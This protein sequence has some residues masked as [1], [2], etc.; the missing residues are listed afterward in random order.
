MLVV[1]VAVL[2]A[3]RFFFSALHDFQ[4]ASIDNTHGFQRLARLSIALGV[5]YTLSCMIDIFGTFSVST[6]RL[7]YIRIYT[8]L[9]CI[10]AMLITVCGMSSTFQYFMLAEDVLNECSVLALAGTN[11]AKSIFRGAPWPLAAASSSDEAASQCVNAWSTSSTSQ[12]TVDFL[13]FHIVPAIFQ[14]FIVCVYYSQV[15]S[16]THAASLCNGNNGNHGN[17]NYRAVQLEASNNGNRPATSQSPLY[18]TASTAGFGRTAD[19]ANTRFNGRDTR[20]GGGAMQNILKK[21][22]LQQQNAASAPV[23]GPSAM[24]MRPQAQRASY[25]NA[26]LANPTA[27]VPNPA[28]AYVQGLALTPTSAAPG[29]PSFSVP[30]DAYGSF[31]AYV[32]EIAGDETQSGYNPVEF[33]WQ[34]RR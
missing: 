15:R 25:A 30:Q 1:G 11:S 21:T 29:P 26:W 27:A 8:F 18:A 32:P 17:N 33:Q 5:M 23:V 9:T 22:M 10:S 24:T 28:M 4:D 14:V 12:I 13:L 19:R 16:P 34:Q 6:Q 20:V 31:N 7:S 3:V 2:N